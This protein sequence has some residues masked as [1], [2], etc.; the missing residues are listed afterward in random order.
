MCPVTTY[1]LSCGFKN[2][3]THRHEMVESES[4]QEVTDLSLG[5]ADKVALL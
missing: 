4:K 3:L 1:R 5:C 2:P